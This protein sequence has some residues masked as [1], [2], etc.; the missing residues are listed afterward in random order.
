[1]KSII[2][3]GNRFGRLTAVRFVEIKDFS[4]YWL[5]KC[6][7]GN[8]KVI[9]AS[10]VKSGR[11]KSCG[12]LRNKTKNNYKHGMTGTPIHKIW[13]NM[14][15]R[16]LDPNNPNY[17]NYGGRGITIC[18]RWMKF[19]NFYQD[20]RNKPKGKTLDRIDNNKSYYK[21]NCRWSTL[22][23]QANNKRNN[24]L[25]T[26]K[27]KTQTIAEWA[28]Y[29]NVKYYIIN[30]RIYRGWNVERALTTLI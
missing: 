1:M 12:C 8:E 24:H 23:Q 10:R 15:S 7:C 27:G 17:E 14:K 4:Q 2:K 28:R 25:L 13:T 26:F 6:S 18:S 5:F 30:N 19:E 21:E 11:I 29:L 22:F 16:C 9:C 3:K 20:M